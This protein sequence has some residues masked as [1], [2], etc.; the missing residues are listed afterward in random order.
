MEGKMTV[1]EASRETGY[2]TEY[3]RQLCRVGKINAEKFG[4]VLVVDRA[5]L[6]EYKQSQ[7]DKRS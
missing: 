1:R 6:L 4:T 7:N 2:S 3:I 5:S